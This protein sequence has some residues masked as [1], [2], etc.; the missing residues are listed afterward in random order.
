MR[1]LGAVL[2]QEGKPVIYISRTLTLAAGR[3]FLALVCAKGALHNYVKGEP[4]SVQTDHKPLETI[5]KRSIATASPSLQRLLLILARYEIQEEYT[6]SKDNSIAD[7]QSR[8]D[9]LS[10][11]L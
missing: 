2:L 7:T 6:S 3:E 1:E 5:W 11:S 4:V 10:P 9:P 8:V